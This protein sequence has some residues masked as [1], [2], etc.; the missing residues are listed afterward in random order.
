MEGL[1]E[2]GWHHPLSGGLGRMGRNEPDWSHLLFSTSCSPIDEDHRSPTTLLPTQCSVPEREAKYHF[3]RL[4]KTKNLINSSFLKLPLSSMLSWHHK[5]N[6]YKFC[7][8]SRKI[9]HIAMPDI[10]STRSL[11]KILFNQF[12]K[13]LSWGW[14]CSSV[15]DSLQNMYHTQNIPQQLKSS[16]VIWLLLHFPLS[17]LLAVSSHLPLLCVELSLIACL[18]PLLQQF[19]DGSVSTPQ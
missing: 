2:F 8:Q 17:C 4:S 6:Q 14:E 11:L 9:F 15:I 19:L 18:F 16:V 10:W 7:C 3:P 12:D 13:D 5:R 1:P